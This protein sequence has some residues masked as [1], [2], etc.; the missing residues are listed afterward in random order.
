MPRRKKSQGGR[1]PRHKG[2]VLRKNRTFRI[3][4]RLDELLEEAATKAGRSA[5]EEI[6]HRLEVSFL[7]ERQ[8]AHLLGSDVGADIL[9]TLRAAMVLEGVTPDWDGDPVRAQ[10]FR[11]IANAVIVAFLKLELVDLPQP[12]DREK[13][14]Q[15]AKE[16]LLRYSPRHVELPAEVMFSDLEEPDFGETLVKEEKPKRAPTR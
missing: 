6:E 11:I 14:M 12:Q 16:L 8:N 1:P 4:A 7:D 13:D 9:R 2:E 5:S 3:R 10:R 15:I